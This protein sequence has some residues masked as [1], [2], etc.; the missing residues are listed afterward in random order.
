MKQ[1]N[2]CRFWDIWEFKPGDPALKFT[3]TNQ[4]ILGHCLIHK[5]LVGYNFICAKWMEKKNQEAA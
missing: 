3:E 4:P 1:C 5:S 2:T